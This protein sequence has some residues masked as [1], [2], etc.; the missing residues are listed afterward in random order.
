[1]KSIIYPFLMLFA[2]PL[3]SAHFCEMNPTEVIP[4][5]LSSCNHN[6]IGIIGDRIKK[7]FFRG[8]DISVDVEENSGQIF[9]QALRADC[10]NTTL[11][12]VTCSGYLQDL[13]LSFIDKSSEIVLLQP[14]NTSWIES[15]QEVCENADESDLTSIVEGFLKGEIPEGYVSFEDCNSPV[16]IKKRLKLKRFSRIVSDK[17]IVFAFR[18]YNESSELQS[19]RECEVNVLDGDWVFI[20]RYRLRPNECALV[21]IGCYR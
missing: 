20:D 5:C 4:V 10:P 19:I 8:T 17:Q 16:Q 3:C 21:L 13:E 11:S 7:V 9:V 14:Q 18:I 1:M 12:I 2:I 15:Q 6:R